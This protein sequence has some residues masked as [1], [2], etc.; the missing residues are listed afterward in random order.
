MNRQRLKRAAQLV[1][2]TAAIFA[3]W[4]VYGLVQEV[5]DQ[6]DEIASL[7]YEI[8]RTQAAHDRLLDRVRKVESILR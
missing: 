3:G 6:R 7:T 5:D 4:Q 1:G 8:Q 2:I